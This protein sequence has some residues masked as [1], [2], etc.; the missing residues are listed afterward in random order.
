MISLHEKS[1]KWMYTFFKNKVGNQE[2][3]NI[4]DS[5]RILAG[6]PS[7]LGC[8]FNAQTCWVVFLMPRHIGSFGSYILAPFSFYFFIYIFSLTKNKKNH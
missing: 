8:C 7:C 3:K 4:L 1:D 2:I 6:K 5:P